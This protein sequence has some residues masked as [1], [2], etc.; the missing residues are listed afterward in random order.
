MKSKLVT[1]LA[2]SIFAFASIGKAD[3]RDDHSRYDRH[4]EHH[5]GYHD[6][7]HGH[8]GDHHDHDDKWDDGDTAVAAGLGATLLSMSLDAATR[9][10]NA[11][12]EQAEPEA[13]A[14][15]PGASTSDVFQNAKA[16]F[17]S[18][19][20]QTFTDEQAAIM[21]VEYNQ[22]VRASL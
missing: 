19:A 7:H 18:Q 16:I 12:I 22:S 14:Y 4:D 1:L 6:G 13:L 11:M 20:G 10:T 9:S 5:D 8:H 21:I 15:T 2:L 3:R 17:E